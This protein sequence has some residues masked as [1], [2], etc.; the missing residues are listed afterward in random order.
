[1][2]PEQ[3]VFYSIGICI[4][5]AVLTLLVS[6]SKGLAGWISFLT[7]GATAVLIAPKAIEVLTSGPNNPHHP[8]QMW[9]T[10]LCGQELRFYVDGLS[11]IFLLLAVVIGVLAALFSISHVCKTYQNKSAAGY[12]PFFLLFIGGMYG[13]LTTTDLML[14]FFLFWQL[15]T[16]PSF[17]LVCYDSDKPGAIAG[18]MK[19]LFWMEA[20]CFAVMAG[21][22]NISGYSHEPSLAYDF[23]ILSEGL[24]EVVA[25]NPGA[26]TICLLLFLVGFGIKVGM[27]PFGQLWIPDAYSSA[28][29]P[30]SALISGV[31]SKTG[32]YGLMRS[33]FWL[34]PADV[35]ASYGPMANWGMALA[36][37]GTITLFTGTMQGLKQDDSKRLLA[38]SSIG[39]L[40][41]VLLAM[42][43]A[44]AV[45][46]SDEAKLMSVAV[47]GFC[48][49]LL[50]AIN[51]GI[52]KGL[53]FFNAGS[54]TQATGTEDMNKMGGL[55]KYMPLTGLTVLIASFGI[56]G[57]PLLNGF[58]SKWSIYVAAIEGSQH[59]K[60]LSVCAIIAILTSAMTLAM[61]I[62]FFGVA[63]LSRRSAVVNEQAAKQGGRLEVGFTQQ[64]PQLC[65]AAI[66]VVI[67]VVPGLAYQVLGQVLETSRQGLANKLADAKITSAG[68]LEGLSVID[69]AAL[70][71]PVILA[72]VLAITFVLVYC[73][74]KQGGSS[75][76]TSAIWLCG[77]AQETDTDSFRYGASNFYGEIKRYFGW[78]GGNPRPQTRVKED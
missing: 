54:M 45:I 67:G 53:L 11:S 50:H 68:A 57:V 75:R 30:A 25:S 19:Y 61:Y 52:F 63:F 34:I 7:T 41:Y 43:V 62:K 26:L 73:F 55:W 8:Q 40:G 6:K 21:A 49:A 17:L 65:L 70:Y 59:A 74:S 71:V 18:A 27:W 72:V 66:C 4:A 16:I 38:Y 10:L 39:Q 14:Y 78:L 3:A 58:V 23:D 77:Y 15:M 32:V 12:Y 48:G 2:T 29:S 31:M 24:T 5:G 1:M 69:G 56:A 76:R 42:G 13:I 28:P 51:H 46:P 35:A 20:A 22:Y 64:L 47:I 44:V 37:L 33:F 36:V 60:Y 9:D